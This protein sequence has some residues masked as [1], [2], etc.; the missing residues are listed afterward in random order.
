[1]SAELSISSDFLRQAGR[2]DSDRRFLA[3]YRQENESKNDLDNQCLERG[4]CVMTN[5]EKFVQEQLKDPEFRAEYDALEPE[6]A[7]ILAISE[8]RK[9]TGLTQVQLAAKTGIDQS[10]ISRIENGEANPS[11]N[12]L[13]RLAAG[14][15]MKLK[16][17]FLPVA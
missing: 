3:C 14:M 12:T 11:L 10:D 5:F 8:A 6:F 16:I 17:E 1:M 15:G 2:G 9:K 4:Q 13:K 7:I